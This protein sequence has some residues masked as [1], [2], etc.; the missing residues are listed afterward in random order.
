MGSQETNSSTKDKGIK[1]RRRKNHAKSYEISV[2]DGFDARKHFEIAKPVVRSQ[3]KNLLESMNGFKFIRT[4]KITFCKRYIDLE[5]KKPTF[6]YKT[7]Y[8]NGKT[9]TVTNLDDI[10][11]GINES[12]NRIMYFVN[13]WVSE[14][15]GWTIDCL[16]GDFLNITLY[17]PLSGSSY[18]KRP[19]KLGNSRKGLINLKNE[20][21]EC[22]RW[23]HIRHLNPQMK[24][25]QRIK[26][27]IR[28]RL[29]S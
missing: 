15:S 6:I 9:K 12:D 28:Q 10:E 2:R 22:F 21:N 23:C 4:L 16:D 13:Q 14:G 24:D 5:T 26:K 8:F 29:T 11:Y 27:M 3:L 19:A 25:P 17:N 7:L 20:D 1:E 18:I